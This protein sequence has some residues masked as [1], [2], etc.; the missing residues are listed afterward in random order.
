L[1]DLGREQLPAIS[2]WPATLEAKQPLGSLALPSAGW[3]PNTAKA[4]VSVAIYNRS[5]AL[6]VRLHPVAT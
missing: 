5:A 6:A 1:H 2:A 3:D 4:F